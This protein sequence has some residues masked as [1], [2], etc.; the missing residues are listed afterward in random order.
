MDGALCPVERVKDLLV[1]PSGDLPPNPAEMLG[2]QRLQGLLDELAGQVDVVIL[3]S[4][5]LLPV[6]DAAILAQRVDGVVL[7]VEA[8]STR[9][10]VAQHAAETL[11]Q[12][13]AHV[14][15][16]VLNAVPMRKAGYYYYYHEYYGGDGQRRE[17]RRKKKGLLG[18][19]SRRRRSAS[20]SK[21]GGRN[22]GDGS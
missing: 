10:T 2:S 1:L 7:V 14:L 12:V 19:L 5:P 22:R 9:R 21:A 8:G 17:R 20:S 13:N 4:P 11:R 18:R 15:G 6:T 16:V 3:D